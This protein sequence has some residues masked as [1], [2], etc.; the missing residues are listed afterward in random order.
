[1]PAPFAREAND[2][3]AQFQIHGVRRSLITLSR[4]GSFRAGRHGDRYAQT[5]HVPDCCN[6]LG[7]GFS[8]L[9]RRIDVAAG[10]GGGRVRL[11]RH[12]R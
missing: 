4:V 2:A 12:S 3:D 6:L 11:R 9:I 7:R 1:M 5:S 8:Q 10:G